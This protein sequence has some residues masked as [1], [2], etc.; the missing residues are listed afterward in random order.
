[1]P[2]TKDKDYDKRIIFN[3]SQCL[4]GLCITDR[5]VLI[6]SDSDG[7]ANLG[8]LFVFDKY[9]GELL[10][11]LAMH[12]DSHVGGITWDGKNLWICNSNNNKI[13]RLSYNT[14]IQMTDKLKGQVIDSRNLTESYVINNTPSGVAYYDGKLWIVT[15]NIL[16][17]GCMKAYI[18]D[19]NVEQLFEQATYSIPKKTQALAFG[20]QGKIYISSSYGRRNSSFIRCYESI[21]MLEKSKAS[22]QFLIELPPS[23]EGIVVEEDILYVLFESAG[24]RY[25]NGTDGLGRSISPIDKILRIRLD[26]M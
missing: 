26:S 19:E 23:S 9:R 12:A 15:H 3:T 2:D 5:Y 21:E 8:E 17:N 14:L 20:K 18:Y 7:D 10:L 24:E 16:L 25:L 6:T 22:Y 1:M 13:E 11:T 4:Q